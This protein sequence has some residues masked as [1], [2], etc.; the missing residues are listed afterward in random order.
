[1]SWG[2]NWLD[3]Q[4]YFTDTLFQNNVLNF[5]NS[6]QQNKP[7]NRLYDLIFDHPD[8]RRMY[9]RR[10]RTVIDQVL[11]PPG[12]G[13]GLRIEARIREMMDQMDPPSIGTSDSSRRTPR[14]TRYS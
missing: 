7:P 8:F 6:A 14:S 11:Q 9:L 3:A 5:Y 13:P 2:R 12:T 10:L 4:G 1:M